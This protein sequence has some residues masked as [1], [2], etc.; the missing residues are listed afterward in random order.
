VSSR[1][2]DVSS[3]CILGTHARGVHT[4]AAASAP[5]PD[6][7]AADSS[8]T[9]SPTL[10]RPVLVKVGDTG[11]YLPFDTD[12]TTMNITTLL[13]ALAASKV[14]G[15]KLKDVD[16]SACTVAIVKNAALDA[17]RVDEPSTEHENVEELKLAKTVGSVA[18][19]AGRS[20]KPGAP[21]FIRVRMPLTTGAASG[22]FTYCCMWPAAFSAAACQPPA[23]RFPPDACLLS[24]W[25]VMCSLFISAAVFFPCCRSQQSSRCRHGGH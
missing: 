11:K 23:M 3:V 6:A 21:L 24:A 7:A 13:E 9:V 19:S 1:A 25:P 16:L 8:G 10:K 14:F 22:E 4:S 18:E 20:D 5:G 2:A 15:V 12:V 17:A